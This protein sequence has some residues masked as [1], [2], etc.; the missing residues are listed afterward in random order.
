MMCSPIARSG[1]KP[2]IAPA[3]AL[4]N[5]TWQARFTMM[6]PSGKARTSGANVPTLSGS[7]GASGCGG[8]ATGSGT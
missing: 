5:S 3:A 1:S 7:A 2:N 6:T 8:A 4:A